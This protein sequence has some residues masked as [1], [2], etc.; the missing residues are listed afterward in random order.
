MIRRTVFYSVLFA[1]GLSNGAQGQAINSIGADT[2]VT[3]HVLGTLQDAGAPHIAC[4]KSC[5]SALFNSEGAEQF[6]VALGVVDHDTEQ[7]FLFEATPDMPEQLRA[8]KN[9]ASFKTT[10]IP[11]GIFL[12]HAHIGHYTGL[13]YLGKE[14]TN[15]SRVP[16]YAMP[17]MADFLKGNGPWSQL[18]ATDNIALKGLQDGED[19]VLTANVRVR[20]FTVPHR[21]EYSETVGYMISGPNRRALFIPDIDKW[22]R[23]ETSIIAAIAKVDIAF[24]DATFFDAAEIQARDITQIPHPLW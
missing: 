22:D 24:L 2:G 12:T 15:A 5:C 13:M 21:D 16:V 9:V 10:D 19:K 11:N 20:P 8:L 7:S 3:L 18:V 17:K 6:V 4:A 23:W 14:A 1:L